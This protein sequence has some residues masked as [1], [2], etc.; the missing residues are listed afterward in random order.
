[1]TVKAIFFGSIGTLIETSDLQRRAFNQAFSEAGLGW[2]WSAEVY[3]QLLTKSGGRG[4]IQDFASQQGI[5]VD[6]SRLHLRKTE[7]FDAL[8]SQEAL[9]L[10]PGIASIMDHAK[11][12]NLPVAFVTSTSKANID[13]VFVA[14]GDQIKRSD[15]SF[16]GNDTMVSKAKPNPDIYQKALSDL[17]LQAQDCIAIEDT[18][19]SMNAALAA[20]IACIGFP[21]AFA[22]AGDFKGA[23]LVTDALAPNHLMALDS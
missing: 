3:K 21:G 23:I 14:L 4:R 11:A 20:G 13:A 17:S 7:I 15:F 8:M 6:A 1:M 19:A 16:I 22:E 9:L 18:V 10:R 12:H 2:N 5:D